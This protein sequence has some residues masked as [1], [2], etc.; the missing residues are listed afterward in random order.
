M[1][2]F[3]KII[4]EAKLGLVW[5]LC[6]EQDGRPYWHY[7]E[8]EKG[9]LEMFKMRLKKG[10]I[11]LKDYGRIIFSGWG[12]EPPEAIKEQVKAMYVP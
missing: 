8:V 11:E 2:N 4:Q 7:L 5:L 9:K 6:G 3:T 1:P 12:A 10:D